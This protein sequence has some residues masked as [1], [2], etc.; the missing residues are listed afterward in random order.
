MIGTWFKDTAT[1]EIYTLPG[2]RGPDSSTNQIFGQSPSSSQAFMNAVEEITGV[3]ATYTDLGAA[4]SAPED[5]RLRITGEMHK[6]P[7][8]EDYVFEGVELDVEPLIEFLKQPQ[9][10][11]L[12]PY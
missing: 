11:R 6:I 10:R 5:L 12:L 8:S 3:V 1:T 9:V 4:V 7:A 2:I